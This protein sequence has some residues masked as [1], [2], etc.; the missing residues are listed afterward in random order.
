MADSMLSAWF[1]KIETH[2][3]ALVVIKDTS[4]VFF[5]VAVLLFA[6]SSTIGYEVLW[7][8]AIFVVGGFFLRKFNSRAAAV[9]LLIVAT[10]MVGATIANLTGTN[11]GGGQN[12]ILA[13]IVLWAAVRAVQATYKFRNLTTTSTKTHNSVAS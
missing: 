9:I 2:E 4:N 8:A 13:V 12:I 11:L 6:L 10:A 7:D 3:Q 1:S 5:F